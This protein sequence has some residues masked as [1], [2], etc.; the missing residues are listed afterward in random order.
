[1]Q[2]DAPSQFHISDI[3]ESFSRRV[4]GDGYDG[5][6][7]PPVTHHNHLEPTAMHAPYMTQRLGS[8]L[9]G[10]TLRPLASSSRYVNSRRRLI[11]G[12]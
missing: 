7:S 12:S 5:G 3:A 10:N 9:L 11:S 1:M 8:R 6:D 4:P 2:Q